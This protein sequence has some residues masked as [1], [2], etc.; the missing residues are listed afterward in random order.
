[1][2]L[3]FWLVAGD[4]ST[5]TSVTLL[6][7]GSESE[8]ESF[9]SVLLQTQET[10]A[11][12]ISGRCRRG[13]L[14]RSLVHSTDTC[15]GLG[16]RDSLWVFFVYKKLLCRTETRT[17]ERMDLQSIRTVLRNLPRRSSKNCDL[18]FANCDIQI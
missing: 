6:F 18:P 2:L 17:H 11:K 16:F 7:D 3:P 12:T 15:T 5:V 13:H 8:S 10:S 4:R 1:M 14:G 9:Y